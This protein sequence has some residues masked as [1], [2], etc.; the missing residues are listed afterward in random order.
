[1]LD[2]I[3]LPCG[4]THVRIDCGLRISILLRESVCK[5][6]LIR[7]CFCGLRIW[8]WGYGNVE[9]IVRL[10]LRY[11]LGLTKHTVF[12]TSPSDLEKYF[13]LN[14]KLPI[15]PVFL[16]AAEARRSLGLNVGIINLQGEEWYKVR[17]YQ[18]I[19]VFLEW[20]VS[21]V[22]FWLSLQ[23]DWATKVGRLLDDL[24]NRP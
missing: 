17:T 21:R 7:W 24:K 6:N 4:S 15:R 16:V 3:N 18:P 2:A 22:E 13:R 5:K 12:T 10:L 9:F 11:F 23:L 8:R 14:E 20:S 19:T 1:M